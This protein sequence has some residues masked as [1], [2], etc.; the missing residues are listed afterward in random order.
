MDII[1]ALSKI[2]KLEREIEELKKKLNKSKYEVKMHKQI[3]ERYL[4]EC[5]R[6]SCLVAKYAPFED[7]DEVIVK[8]K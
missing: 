2:K 4:D 7:Y 3:E 1:D 5:D 6:L 8:Q